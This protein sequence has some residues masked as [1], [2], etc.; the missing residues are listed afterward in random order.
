MDS[1]NL[2]AFMFVSPGLLFIT[3]WVILEA[4]VQVP[5]WQDNPAGGLDRQLGLMAG[6]RY[7]L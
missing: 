1:D 5:V 2:E 6:F 3:R 7:L 4:L